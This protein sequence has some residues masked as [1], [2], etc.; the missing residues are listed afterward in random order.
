MAEASTEE[1]KPESWRQQRRRRLRNQKR[2]RVQVNVSDGGGVGVFTGSGYWWRRKW[3][4]Q[5]SK[6]GMRTQQR[7]RRRWKMT[8]NRRRVRW[9]GDINWGV[10]YLG[11]TTEAAALQWWAWGIGDHGRGVVRGRRSR[12]LDN[13]NGGVGWGRRRDNT[14]DWTSL[15]AEAP[16]CLRDQGI[17]NNDG[18]VGRVRWARGIRNNDGGVGI[19]WGINDASEGSEPTTEAAWIYDSPKKY[20][21][22]MEASA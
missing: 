4:R 2:Q 13:G 11:T 7:R 10:E 1:D 6:M 8:R 15:T 19:G 5:Q 14:S 3:R 16:M 17:E 12:G 18:G 21:T 20:T 9:I 22:T